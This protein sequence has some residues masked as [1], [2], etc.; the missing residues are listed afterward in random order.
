M[1]KGSKTRNKS[2]IGIVLLTIL[3]LSSCTVIKEND[4]ICKISLSVNLE[5]LKE[6][7]DNF[8]FIY[9]ECAL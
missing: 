3:A 6:E 9:G 7:Q 8:T 1:A 4:I 2:R 5:V